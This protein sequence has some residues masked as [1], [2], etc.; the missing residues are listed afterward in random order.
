MTSSCFPQSILWQT[1]GKKGC[2]AFRQFLDQLAS[3]DNESYLPNDENPNE[4]QQGDYEERRRIVVS[5]LF[6][7]RDALKFYPKEAPAYLADLV[8]RMGQVTAKAKKGAQGEDVPLEFL[9]QELDK[10]EKAL[11]YMPE[12]NLGGVPPAFLEFSK[13]ASLEEDG[14][15][16]VGYG[17]PAGKSSSSESKNSK[18]ECI[19]VIDD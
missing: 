6:R 12:Q 5:L 8:G 13:R 14:L 2:K 4:A 9:R 10:L 18:G 15:E 11:Y 1:D 19:E 3:V 17:G 16:I 7:E